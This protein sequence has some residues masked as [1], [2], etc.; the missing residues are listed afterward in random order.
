MFPTSCISI[1]SGGGP[2]EAFVTADAQV[3]MPPVADREQHLALFDGCAPGKMVL[4][5]QSTGEVSLLDGG[6]WQ[7]DYSDSGAAFV[8]SPSAGSRWVANILRQRLGRTG[9]GRLFIQRPTETGGKESSF[10]DDLQVQF[11]VRYASLE[12]PSGVRGSSARLKVVKARLLRDGMGL[13]F[14][15]RDFQALA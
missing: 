4:L 6:D 13:Y 7:L 12:W 9:A 10:V 5:N 14:Q 3:S 8:S 15:L 2:T 1:I 11:A